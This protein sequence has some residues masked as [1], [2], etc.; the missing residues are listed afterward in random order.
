MCSAPNL[1]LQVCPPSVDQAMMVVVY[2]QVDGQ[3]VLLTT[4]YKGFT[5]ALSLVTCMPVTKNH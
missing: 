1:A 5:T 4:S 2:A 3:K